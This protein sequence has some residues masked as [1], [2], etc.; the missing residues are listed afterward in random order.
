MN[1]WTDSNLNTQRTPNSKHSV[2]GTDTSGKCVYT[3][4][5]FGYRSDSFSK[6][7]FKVMSVGCSHTEGIGVN[8]WETYP[9]SFCS[10]LENSVNINLGLG[11]SSNDYIA[12]TI[13][14]FFDLIK[15]DLILIQYTYTHRREIYTENNEIF[16]Y[17][18]NKKWGYFATETGNDLH[19]HL[20][21]I[22]N[23]NENLV[24]WYKNHLLIKNFLQNKN[25]NWIWNGAFGIPL[26]INEHNRFDGILPF[27]D[28]GADNMHAGPSTHKDYAYKLYKFILKEKVD[29]IPKENY[30]K[31]K[32]II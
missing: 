25:C 24:N 14:N 17:T 7:G 3:Y 4:N 10:L 23:E 9:Y 19:N 18:P 16:A 1:H 15:P 2:M 26:E 22:Q 30:K 32:N 13:I 6:E 27:F 12:R 20:T 8:D 29:F 11:A 5:E 21:L 31:I 28:Y